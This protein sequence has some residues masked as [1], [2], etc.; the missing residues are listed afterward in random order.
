MCDT[1]VMVGPDRVLFAKNSDRDANEGQGLEWHPARDWPEGAE[2][3]CTE[4]TI[5]QVEHT[6]AVLISRPFWMWGAEMGANEHGVVIGNEAVFTREPVPEHGLTGMDL[7]RLTLERSITAVG[8]LQILLELLETHGQGGRG[9]FE[10][11]SFRYH[12]SFLIA[13]ATEAWV[14]ETSGRRHAEE[15]VTSG[16]RTISNVLTIP[17]FREE[18]TNRLGA[19]KS[20]VAAADRR[21]HRS[22]DLA[23]G[24][25]GIPELIG[26]LRDHGTG[27]RA[28]RFHW[29]NGT[30]G[31][32]C[33]HGGGLLA[34]SVSTASWVAELRPRGE[35]HWV[36]ASSGPCVS[37]FKPVRVD[38]PLDLGPFPGGTAD[39][40]PWWQHERLHRCWLRNPEAIGPCFLDER[41]GVEARWLHDP[42]EP[43]AAFPAWRALL[44]RWNAAA[45]EL[46]APNRLPF[47]AR[48]YWARRDRAA[49][50][51]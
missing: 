27:A 41:D 20:A 9:G 31:A 48:R 34:H 1:M 25:A 29:L 15:R 47:V 13:D 46:D 12:N 17:P 40:S 3:K 51:A 42:P 5:P 44:K 14:I 6:H 45:A 4:V 49:G 28:P 2:V 19:V 36:T 35:R 8:A 38:E 32:V 22:A 33:M 30:L 11:P 23:A 10:D 24:A 16:V 37:L 21:R 26:A 39:D 43:A 50:L 7:V 18:A